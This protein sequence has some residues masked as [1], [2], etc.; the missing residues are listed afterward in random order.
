[1]YNEKTKVNQ[2]YEKEIYKYKKQQIKEILRV[3]S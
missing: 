1:M 2:S 3:H